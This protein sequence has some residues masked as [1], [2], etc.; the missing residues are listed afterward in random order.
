MRKILFFEKLQIIK[1]FWHIVDKNSDWIQVFFPSSLDKKLDQLIRI[2]IEFR[3][4]SRVAW[5]RSWTNIRDDG[6]HSHSLGLPGNHKTFVQRRPY[7]FN[8][9]P[10]LYKCFVFYVYSFWAA[11]HFAGALLWVVWLITRPIWG[12]SRNHAGPML[13]QHWAI[14]V[15]LVCVSEKTVLV[16]FPQTLVFNFPTRLFA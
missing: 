8:V 2:L 10:T 11:S 5:I 13:A 14:I 4:F 16:F 15:P 9:G 12:N 7:L 6:T 3:F 1:N